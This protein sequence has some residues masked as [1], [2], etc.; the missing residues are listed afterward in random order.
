MSKGDELAA[1]RRGASFQSAG[2]DEFT[3][4]LKTLTLPEFVRKYEATEEDYR[5]FLIMLEKGDEIEAPAL[6]KAKDTRPIEMPAPKPTLEEQGVKFTVKDVVPVRYRGMARRDNA[7]VIP[8]EQEHSSS[9]IIPPSAKAKERVGRI[10]ALG[11]MI[12][13]LQVGQ[14]VVFDAFAAHGKEIEL[15]DDQ[16]IPRGHLLL[17]DDDLQVPLERVTPSD[18][19]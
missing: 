11:P 13:D 1:G 5:M 16:G 19:N 10:V 12:T 14:L 17:K 9:L 3:H 4:D 15:I 18:A 8:V 6:R 7:L 2:G